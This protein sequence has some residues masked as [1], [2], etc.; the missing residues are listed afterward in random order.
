MPIRVPAILTVLAVAAQLTAAC[1]EAA[2]RTGPVPPRA[3]GATPTA[4]PGTARPS[5]KARPVRRPKAPAGMTVGYAMYDRAA[6]RMTIQHH[7]HRRF[8][9]ASVVK[10][11]IALDYLAAHRAGTEIP[12]SDRALLRSMLRSSDDDAA[13]TLWTRGGRVRVIER[14]VAAL[15]LTDT[16]PPPAGKPGFWGYTAISAADVVRIYRYLLDPAHRRSGDFIMG[17]LRRATRCAADG[18][19]QYVGIPAALPRPWAIKQGWSGYGS[20]PPRR[21]VRVSTSLHAPGRRAAPVV[22]LV[23]PVLHT[24][25][26]VGP[27]DHMIVVVLSLQPAGSRWGASAARLTAFTKAVY[28][29]GGGR[30]R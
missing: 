17:H 16:A 26:T 2:P 23:R 21:C 24:T 1:Q 14:M 15:R 4:A 28:R 3:A 18:F 20:V 13:T 27:G 6:R 25:G 5:A 19:D 30:T 22:D 9:S 29:A 10:I 11:L 8:R 12:A 7:A